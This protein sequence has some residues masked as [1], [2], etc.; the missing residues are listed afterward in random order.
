MSTSRMSTSA[1]APRHTEP[2]LA[3][4]KALRPRSEENLASETLELR[5]RERTPRQT[6]LKATQ[7]EAGSDA[8]AFAASGH[9]GSALSRRLERAA[10]I[11]LGRSSLGL[12]RR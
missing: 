2:R 5:P 6:P 1:S 8:I 9:P 7:V 3:S 4:R 10:L 12:L 11:A